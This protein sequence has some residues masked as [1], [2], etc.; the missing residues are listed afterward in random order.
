MEGKMVKQVSF[1]FL[2]LLMLFFVGC[3]PMFPISHQ[4]KIY[5][6]DIKK[7]EVGSTKAE[8]YDLLGKPNFLENDRYCVYEVC[9]WHGGLVIIAGLSA[10][11]IDFGSEIYRILLE[12]N[13][14]DRLINYEVEDGVLP[15]GTGNTVSRIHSKIAISPNGKTLAVLSSNDKVWLINLET[16]EKVELRKEYTIFTTPEFS[17]DSRKFLLIGNKYVKVIDVSN[18]S[19]AFLFKGHGEYSHWAW[20]PKRVTCLA[21]FPDGK[22]VA[23]GGSRGFI[24]IWKLSTGT[25]IMSFK[26]HSGEVD[27]IEISP[28]GKIIAGGLDD[29]IRIWDS[30]TG[31]E[32][33]TF[34][35][36]EK[37]VDSIEISPDGKIIATGSDATIRIWDSTTGNEL[38]QMISETD[39]INGMPKQCLFKFSPDGKLFAVN[40]GTHVELWSINQERDDEGIDA[41]GI[42]KGLSDVFLLP[43]FD[44]RS[45]NF[46]HP[47]LDFSNDGK[48][49][50]ASYGSI[51]VYNLDTKK[52]LWSYN[53]K[54]VAPFPI[55]SNPDL[56]SVKYAALHPNGKLLFIYTDK[57]DIE[58]KIDDLGVSLLNL[59]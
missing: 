54:C 13:E 26:A 23:T 29:N 48:I 22:K 51:V 1:V 52:S 41:Q 32:I 14:N 18:H 7:I 19:K 38:Y 4:S 28:D 24:K 25:E 8:V 53:N 45:L 31:N 9:G 21:F 55:P 46:G 50:A 39:V 47:S 56:F 16:E 40:R 12:F 3:F 43:V 6:E 36:H 27:S 57:G 5:E 59:K 44:E 58:S 10:M 2:M 33:M 15:A 20:N 34:K 30:T 49:L 35:T 42:F 17:P 37:K 11:G